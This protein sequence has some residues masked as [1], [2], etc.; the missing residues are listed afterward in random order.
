MPGAEF[1][2]LHTLFDLILV[3]L[4]SGHRGGSDNME[5]SNGACVLPLWRLSFHG[6]HY[7]LLGGNRGDDHPSFY[8]LSPEAHSSTL[9]G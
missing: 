4:G 9:A 5:G 6:Q 3:T 7:K 8:L 2:A 1:S